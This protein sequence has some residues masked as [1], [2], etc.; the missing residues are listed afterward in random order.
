MVSG[1]G[2]ILNEVITDNTEG[3]ERSTLQ[4]TASNLE[5]YSGRVHNIKTEFWLSGS[6]ANQWQDLKYAS[7]NLIGT[8]FG[9]VNRLSVVNKRNSPKIKS[10]VGTI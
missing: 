6:V 1:S 8:D 3:D 4:I 5:T 7:H 9:K 10:S 2:F